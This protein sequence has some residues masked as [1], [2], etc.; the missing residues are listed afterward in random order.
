MALFN[1]GEARFK[2][3]FWTLSVFKVFY[4][5][6]QMDELTARNANFLKLMQLLSGYLWVNITFNKLSDLWFILTQQSIGGGGGM[7][8]VLW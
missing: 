3:F 2:F 5:D 4:N 7:S 8:M 1:I 6:L